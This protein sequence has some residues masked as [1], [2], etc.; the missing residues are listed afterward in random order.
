MNSI[1]SIST[2]ENIALAAKKNISKNSESKENI[3]E[4]Y[5]YD[6]NLNEPKQSQ[7]TIDNVDLKKN[8]A[9]KIQNHGFHKLNAQPIKN[10]DQC[11]SKNTEKKEPL[12]S[13]TTEEKQHSENAQSAPQISFIPIG[14]QV[15]IDVSTT[16]NDDNS[17]SISAQPTATD[18]IHQH[19]DKQSTTPSNPEE[20]IKKIDKNSIVEDT[21]NKES[22]TFDLHSSNQILDVEGESNLANVVSGSENATKTKTNLARINKDNTQRPE[23]VPGNQ[24]EINT[25]PTHEIFIQQTTTGTDKSTVSNPALNSTKNSTNQKKSKEDSC[26]DLTISKTQS[27]IIQKIDS[28]FIEKN[29]INNTDFQKDSIKKNLNQIRTSPLIASV[30]INQIFKTN[31][32]LSNEQKISP[33]NF[34]DVN[35]S[36]SMLSAT[37]TALHKS[38]QSGILLRLDPPN[39]GHLDI[40]IRIAP[41]GSINVVFL[42]SSSDAAH[43]LQSSLPQLGAA[44]AQSGLSL[45]QTEIGGQFSESG[46]H[47]YQSSQNKSYHKNFSNLNKDSNASPLS[48]TGLSFY[49]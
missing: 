5:S 30:N 16:Q 28:K 41:Q 15:S 19:G 25:Q 31:S 3:F 34:S 49:A 10:S 43:A 20:T 14:T 36:P 44:L 24:L 45:G 22:M 23:H 33:I 12:N 8:R 46:R 21:E 37:I 13:T 38:N 11:S 35:L 27:A 18:S 17:L 47:S 4:I 40:Q 1:P 48:V 39:L 42:P 2:T 29:T 7:K 32:L 26:S 9:T 6:L